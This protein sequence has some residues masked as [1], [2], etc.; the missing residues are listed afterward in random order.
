MASVQFVD[1]NTMIDYSIVDGHVRFFRLNDEVLR[2]EERSIAAAGWRD[3]LAMFV[4]HMGWDLGDARY[5]FVNALE[6]DGL[7]PPF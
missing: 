2:D 4:V 1:S 6:R 7:L 5:A 3:R